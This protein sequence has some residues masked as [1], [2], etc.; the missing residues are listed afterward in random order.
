VA[1]NR[2]GGGKTSD[3]DG[4]MGGKSPDSL[5]EWLKKGWKKAYSIRKNL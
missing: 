4:T 3:R 1:A 2:E 5:K